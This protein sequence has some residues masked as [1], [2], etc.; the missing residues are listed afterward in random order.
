MSNRAVF[1]DR[2]GTLVEHYDYLTDPSQVQL[3][4][5]T[6]AALRLLRDHGFLLVMVTNQSAV[7]RGLV[8][9]AKLL[10]IHDRLK[11]LLS[12]EGA[13]LDQIY[14]CPYHPEGSVAKYRRES[15]LRKPSPG[16]L[17]LAARELDID[18]AQS[19]VVGD[20]DRD[21]QAGQAARCR[22]ILLE[23]RKRSEFVHR[24]DSEPDF[25]AVNLQE[26]AN[27]IVR[28]A[29]EPR[30]GKEE[31]ANEEEHGEAEP[32]EETGS[33]S[34][35]SGTAAGAATA[36][37]EGS[38]EVKDTSGEEASQEKVSSIAARQEEIARRKAQKHRS[39]EVPERPAIDEGT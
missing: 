35:E 19:W 16:M 11:A 26:A 18:L 6:T 39:A 34:G 12:E 32:T 4:G 27:L 9:E 14:Y 30:A 36:A 37:D 15:D 8:T 29:R 38:G 24:G 22:T 5:T 10:E 25:L 23:Q 2:D 31:Q 28:H 13:Y 1:L 3:L 20:D 17:Q 21:V 33:D 7:A